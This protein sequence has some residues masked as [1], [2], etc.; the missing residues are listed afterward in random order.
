MSDQWGPP[1][2]TPSEREP[3]PTGPPPPGPAWGQPPAG[4][5]PAYQPPASEP[6][7]GHQPPAGYPPLPASPG[8][9]FEPPA[10][11]PG[12]PGPA[13]DPQYGWE[14]PPAVFQRPATPEPGA[15][16]VPDGLK[17]L[18]IVLSVVKAI[19]L[20]LMLIGLFLFVVFA[21]SIDDVN[22]DLD[23]I[24]DGAI[25]A[26]VLIGLIIIAIGATLLWVQ[27]RGV[28]KNRLLG[29]LVVAAV[30]AALD[31]VILLGTIFGDDPDTGGI[32]V[33]ALVFGAQAAVLGLTIQARSRAAGR[34]D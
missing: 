10:S 23:G 8:S 26:I 9:P 27:A 12:L 3:E 5:P 16:G 21:E 29:V 33:M 1:Q 20:A 17:V 30:M 18:A 31:L 6:P 4:P 2:G 24:L 19:P 32:V 25:I 11:A 34:A 13:P 7:P 14:P 22:N 28:V 15:A